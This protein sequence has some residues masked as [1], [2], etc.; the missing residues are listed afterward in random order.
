MY[1]QSVIVIGI[2]LNIRGLT[3]NIYYMYHYSYSSL[4]GVVFTQLY[5]VTQVH[6]LCRRVWTLIKRIYRG[7]LTFAFIKF[8][9]SLDLK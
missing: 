4:D 6:S 8:S 3:L 7:V 1:I 9:H 5:V 2:S